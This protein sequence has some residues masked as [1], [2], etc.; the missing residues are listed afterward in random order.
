[1]DMA[2]FSTLPVPDGSAPAIRAAK[3]QILTISG[4][5]RPASGSAFPRRFGQRHAKDLDLFL[6]VGIAEIAPV[7]ETCHRSSSRALW[8]HA[9][10][11][12]NGGVADERV[13]SLLIERR[14]RLK[15][16]ALLESQ[17]RPLCLRA[18]HA[19]E[20]T[21]IEPL[22]VKL[23]LRPANVVFRRIRGIQPM[24]RGFRSRIRN[25]IGISR[26]IQ[27]GSADSQCHYRSRAED[28]FPDH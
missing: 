17:K 16:V 25:I 14:C 18:G 13:R 15:A 6:P 26:K 11:L 27:S 12:A 19:V 3:R 2:A 20:R 1:I 21:V 8:R 4:A 28:K 7:R 5:F 10:S 22:H 23:Y 9:R 24:V